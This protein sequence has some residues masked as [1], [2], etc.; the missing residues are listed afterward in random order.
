MKRRL[1][2]LLTAFA[3]GLG[4]QA[5]ADDETQ[6]GASTEAT[7]AVSDGSAAATDTASDPAAAE[8]ATTDDPMPM[9]ADSD[10]K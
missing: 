7:A 2:M 1:L 8:P 9:P 6:T 4:M 10:S 5:L 3:A